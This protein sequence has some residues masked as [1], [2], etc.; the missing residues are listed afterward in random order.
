MREDEGMTIR[1]IELAEANAF[2]SEH[3][4]H[5]GQTRGHRFSLAAYDGGRLCGVAIVGRPVCR[6]YDIRTTVEVTR[7]CTDGTRNACSF[8][9]GAC[10]KA[11]KAL[12]YEQIITYV[13]ESETGASVRAANYEMDHKTRG[14]E[15]STPS[16]RR[17]TKAPTCAKIMYSKRL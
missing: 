12:G 6:A 17:E 10:A 5:H 1:H 3:H 2:V 14:G 16:R 4:R 7:L 8:L 13:L 15:W 9:Y 11:A